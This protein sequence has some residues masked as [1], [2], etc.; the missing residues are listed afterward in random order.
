MAGWVGLKTCNTCKA[1]K[2]RTDFHTR[3]AQCKVCVSASNKVKYYAEPGFWRDSWY[4]KTYGITLDDYNARLTAQGNVCA[5]CSSSQAARNFDVDHDHKTGRVRGLLCQTCNSRLLGNL[6]AVTPA[7]V[8]S[9][10]EAGD[11]PRPY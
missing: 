4:R 10:L 5:I 11:D 2:P 7:R 6:D 8:L 3:S 9:Y 1:E